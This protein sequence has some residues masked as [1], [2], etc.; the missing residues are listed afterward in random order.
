MRKIGSISQAPMADEELAFED[1]WLL[2]RMATVTGQVTEA[3]EGYR[4]AEASRTLYDFAWDEFCS[5]YVEM[6]KARFQD[7]Q[8]APV[9]R[10]V[11]AHALDQLL[12][13]LHPVIPFITEG[14]WELLAQAAPVRGLS[15]P[16][17]PSGSIMTA[18]WPQPESAHRNPLIEEQFAL[19]QQVLGALREIRS[20]QGI[21]PREPIEFSVRCADEVVALL[22]PMETYFASM[23]GAS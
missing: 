21:S 8:A 17:E 6:A 13:L 4:F 18:D 19:F 20:R 15:E 5:F 11:L 23:A 3:L 9:A 7:D 12:R 22:K 16:T 1:R 2:S 14:V 10:R